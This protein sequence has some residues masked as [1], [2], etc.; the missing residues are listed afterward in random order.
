MKSVRVWAGEALRT[1]SCRLT[2]LALCE[3]VGRRSAAHCQ[4][5]WHCVTV[6]PMIMKSCVKVWAEET[7][8]TASCRL[9]RLA[10]C[11]CEATDEAAEAIAHALRPE[12]SLAALELA[13]N[14]FTQSGE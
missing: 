1:A 5:A 8:R 12:G 11:D 6:R 4:L 10:L 14:Q 9:T 2:R 3:G 7:L 13:S